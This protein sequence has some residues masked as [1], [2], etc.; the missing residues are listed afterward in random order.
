MDS[1]T[2]KK[3]AEDELA[4]GE[5]FTNSHGITP[6]NVRSL[7]VEPFA[8]RT[9]PDDLLTKPRDMW[10][11]LQERSTPRDGYVIV[12]DPQNNSWGVAEHIRGGDYILII[13]APSLARALS[14]M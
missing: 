5:S 2:A 6:E 4:R 11:V 10:V 1:F 13:S 3:L 12:Y 7:L 14:G 9:D 8:V